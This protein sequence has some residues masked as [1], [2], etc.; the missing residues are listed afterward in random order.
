[1]TF[2]IATGIQALPGADVPETEVSGGFK[3]S[4]MKKNGEPEWKIDGNSA[5]FISPTLIEVND[6]R[7][8]YFA[9]EGNTVVATTEKARI[10]KEEEWVKTDKFVTIVTR[11]SVTTGTGLEWDIGKKRIRMFKNVRMVYTDPDEKGLMR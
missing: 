9:D 11:N 6:L 3:L 4:A 5:T 1:M 8:V 2:V 7:A 10:N